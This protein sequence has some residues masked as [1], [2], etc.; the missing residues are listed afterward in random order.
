M[1]RMQCTTQHKASKR[2]V[3]QAAVRA[4]GAP[5]VAL[6]IALALAGCGASM[7]VRPVDGTPDPGTE[8]QRREEY[9]GHEEFRN[10]YGL[11]AIK[12]HYAYARGA[13]GE[14]VTLG[15]VDSGVDPGHPKFEGKLETSYVGGYDPDFSTC[16]EFGPDGECF[17]G[18]GHGTVVAGIMAAARRK[19]PQAGPAS[20]PPVH[21]VAFDAR[22]ISVGVG[23]RDLEE[24]VDEIVAE[25]PENPTPEQ[26]AELQARVLD[27]EAQLERELE[28]DTAIAFVRLNGRVTAINCSFGVFGNIEDFGAEELRERFANVIAAMT[29]ADVAAGERTVYVWA[30]GN[31]HGEIGPDGSPV[32]ASSVE[33]LP[34]LPARIPELRGHSLAVVA[35]NP[36][37]TIADFSNRCGIAR[38]FCL[39]APGVNIT[40]TAPAFHCDAGASQ[41]FITLEEAG[42]SSAAPFVTGGIGLLAQHFQGQLGNDEIVERILATADKTGVYANTA[43]YGQG[44]LD[45]DAATRPVGEKRMLTGLSLSGASSPE[46][47]SALH[48]SPAFGDSLIRGLASAHVASFDEL[49][50]PF[51]RRLG[52]YLRPVGF[53]GSS[54]GERLRSLGRD[55]R[56]TPWEVDGHGLQVRL[57]VVPTPRNFN[58]DPGVAPRE[59]GAGEMGVNATVRRGEKPAA[60]ASLSVSHDF[61]DS[62]LALGYRSR[63]ASEF[64]IGAE[65]LAPG[66]FADAEAF[67]SPFLGF[68]RNGISIG[69]A[70]SLGTGS[71][72]AAA[73]AASAPHGDQRDAHSDGITGALAEYR[74]GG[75]VDSGL[76]LQAGWMTEANGSVGSRT[77][78]AFGEFRTGTML[79]GLTAYRRLSDNWALLGS[80]YAG[81]H[82]T[83]D[84]R[85][86]IV[87]GMSGLWSSAFAAGI[88]G[89]DVARIGDRLGFRLSQPLR[90]EAGHAEL[91][92]VSGRSPDGRVELEQATLG[93][94]PSGRQFD[95]EA[96][97]SRPWAGG[98]VHMATIASQDLGHARGER[99][100]SILARYSRQF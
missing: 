3:C 49:D 80:A 50:A 82:R 65:E 68:T 47:A 53:S 4:A 87:R 23:S 51:F 69:L 92:W 46:Q 66:T 84:L 12:A 70:S 95:L 6:I 79:T 44:F 85:Q 19:G 54:L 15:I 81:V 62:R 59:H 1:T 40:S 37:G 13:T 14:G 93:L 90:V 60:L 56:G 16:D 11:G 97:Y 5:A 76:S 73:F 22:V 26:I 75:L 36:Q 45:L 98:Q 24:V 7:T 94:E 2:P 38:E 96:A 33:I 42:T 55:P 31:A 28:R 86:G 52:D 89:Q 63:L 67:A 18:L 74:F 71:F 64:G 100:V 72:R 34:G 88:V 83:D 48:L 27:V 32:S 57:D 10:Q 35:T 29:Q 21:G 30:A 61:G 58:D 41:C 78:G 43:V 77:D 91:R 9:A 39:A 20:G 25:Y 8:E 99:E 17:S